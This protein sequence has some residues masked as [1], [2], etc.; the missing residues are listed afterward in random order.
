MTPQIS[1]TLCPTC[2]RS[3]TT[4]IVEDS[5]RT[6]WLCRD[7]G[8]TWVRSGVMPTT[9]EPESAPGPPHPSLAGIVAASMLAM[10]LAVVVYLVAAQVGPRGMP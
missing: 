10:L 3:D 8:E 7:C 5:D 4:V 1:T 9:W 6:V 2:L